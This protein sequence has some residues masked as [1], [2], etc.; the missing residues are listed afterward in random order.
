MYCEKT[1]EELLWR[2]RE[3]SL[4]APAVLVL[5]TQRLLQSPG[6]G[7]FCGDPES[8][9]RAPGEGFRGCGCLWMGVLAFQVPGAC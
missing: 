4:P 6:Q 7:G 9:G 8:R 1:K 3:L 2:S 5:R